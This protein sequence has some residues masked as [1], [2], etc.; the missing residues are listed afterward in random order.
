MEYVQPIR[1]KQKIK[2][3]KRLLKQR[4]ARDYLFFV[5]GI[6]T[7]MRVSDMLRIRAHDVIDE[8]NKIREF[9][10]VRCENGERMKSFY[11]NEKTK[12]AIKVYI[13]AT[14]IDR[15]NYLFK[16]R[17]ADNQPIT[18]QQAYRIINQAAREVGI[19]DKIGTHTLRKTFGYHAFIGGISISIIQAIFNHQT[20]KETL[21]YIG[22]DQSDNDKIKVD[23]NL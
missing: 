14:P 21:R 11:L 5:F 19:T 9:C 7:G 18:R 8:S 15:S 4:S 3:L 16:S 12:R 13:S 2:A 6:N 10:N 17:K 23:V 22:M 1:D 20:R